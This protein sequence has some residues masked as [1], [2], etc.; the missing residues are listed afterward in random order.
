METRKD[1]CVR[2][3]KGTSLGI[4]RLQRTEKQS[5]DDSELNSERDRRIARLRGFAVRFF[6]T[7]RKETGEQ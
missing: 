5:E 7:R 4:A 2:T 6:I 3:K 1:N